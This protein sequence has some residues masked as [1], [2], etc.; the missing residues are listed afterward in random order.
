[1]LPIWV[2]DPIG[3][4]IPFLTASTPAIIVVATAPKP[5][6]K[7]PNLPLAGLILVFIFIY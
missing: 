5:G 4:D 7:I 6:I 2:K 1:M 3:C